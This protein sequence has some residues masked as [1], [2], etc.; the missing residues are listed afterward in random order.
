[1]NIPQYIY[2]STEELQRYFALLVQALQ[3][4]LGGAGFVLPPQTTTSVGL[5]TLA[6]SVPVLQVGT[7]WFNTTTGKMQFISV[8]ANP[9]GPTNA[10]VQTITST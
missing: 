1:M 8:A 3:V 9:A 4:N 5:I 7:M 2:G 6:T 10:T